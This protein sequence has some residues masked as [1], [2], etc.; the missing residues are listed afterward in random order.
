[1]CAVFREKGSSFTVEPVVT[2]AIVTEIDHREGD[3]DFHIKDKFTEFVSGLVITGADLDV[4]EECT[5][6][7]GYILLGSDEPVDQTS[8]AARFGTRE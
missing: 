7:C 8:L 2:L 5:N 4:P 6:F 3:R 1:M